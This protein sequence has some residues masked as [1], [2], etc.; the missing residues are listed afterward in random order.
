VRPE[1]LDRIF[2]GRTRRRSTLGLV[3][4][5]RAW[6]SNEL[7]MRLLHVKKPPKLRRP[8]FSTGWAHLTGRTTKAAVVASKATRATAHRAAVRAML[9]DARGGER[10]EMREQMR[11]EV[12]I[13]S[14]LHLAP[15]C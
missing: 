2:L 1:E 11:C 4:I 3:W 10:G 8:W 9:E 13:S 12:G 14:L 5:H 6:D 7:A 15:R